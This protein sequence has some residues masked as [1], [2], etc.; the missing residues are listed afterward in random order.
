MGNFPNL[1]VFGD[2]HGF[3][4]CDGSMEEDV[5]YGI[6]EVPLGEG[7]SRIAWVTVVGPKDINKIH[8]Y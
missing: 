3:I 4:V 6:D 7:V 1:W 2:G 8:W 5:G